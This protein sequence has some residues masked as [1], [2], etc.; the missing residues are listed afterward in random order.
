MNI[1]NYSPSQEG[2]YPIFVS[3]ENNCKHIANNIHRAKIRK[4]KI[5]GD[6]FKRSDTSVERCDYLL[7]NDA[8][9]TSYYIELKGTDILKASRQ[10]D[11]TVSIFS[12]SLPDYV[13]FPRIIFMSGTHQVNGSKIIKWK[14]KHKGL[15]VVTRLQYSENI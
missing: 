1:N 9:K 11:N 6:V 14:K 8:A 3:E 2:T 4:Y 7:L 5:D 13:I 10:I 12:D 15:A